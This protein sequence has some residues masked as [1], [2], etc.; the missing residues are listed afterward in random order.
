MRHA[1]AEPIFKE[2]RRFVAD[3]DPA[4]VQQV[5]DIAL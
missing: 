4:Y 1:Q 2:T 5:F 3:P